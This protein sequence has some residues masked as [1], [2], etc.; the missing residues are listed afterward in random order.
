MLGEADE[1]HSDVIVT[2][3]FYIGMTKLAQDQYFRVMQTNPSKFGGRPKN[4]STIACFSPWNLGKSVS[5]RVNR[6]GRQ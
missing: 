2:D 6:F 5:R 1:T 4:L 3:V